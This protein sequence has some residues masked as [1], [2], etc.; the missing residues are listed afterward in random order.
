MRKFNFRLEFRSTR[1][2]SL[3][4]GRLTEIMESCVYEHDSG[5]SVVPRETFMNWTVKGGQL[6]GLDITSPTLTATRQD[7]SMVYNVMNAFRQQM[8]GANCVRRN[9]GFH[10]NMDISD[11]NKN[12]LRNLLKLVSIF[13]P[14]IFQIFPDSRTDNG[15]CKALSPRSYSWINNFDPETSAYNACND[16]FDQFTATNLGN[17]LTN[18]TIEFRYAASTVRGI[19]VVNWIKLLLILIELAKIGTVPGRRNND[20]N[21][22]VRYIES[23]NTNVDWLESHKPRVVNWLNERINACAESSDA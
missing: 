13:E 2:N 15:Y 23:N 21:S 4:R 11:L 8:Q 22:L 5:R 6:Q 19:K 9:C 17:Y 14:N 16:I 10:V 7:L 1:D 12:Q 20:P 18:G 3:N